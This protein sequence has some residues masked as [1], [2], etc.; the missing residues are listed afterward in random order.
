MKN[1][2][3]FIPYLENDFVAADKIIIKKIVI[4]TIIIIVH[5]YHIQIHFSSVLCV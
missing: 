3:L 2:T 4:V 1:E 5:T